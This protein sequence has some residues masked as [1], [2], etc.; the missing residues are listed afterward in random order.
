LNQKE[1]GDFFT[2]K[3]DQLEAIKSEEEKNKKRR[4]TMGRV[5]S[6]RAITEN[7]VAKK[8]QE[9]IENIRKNKSKTTKPVSEIKIDTVKYC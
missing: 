2:N 4:N 6:V 5:I 1:C 8:V 3:E 9:H 7:G